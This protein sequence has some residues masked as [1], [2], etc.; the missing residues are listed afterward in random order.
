MK[1]TAP[2]QREASKAA[3]AGIASKA[4]LNPLQL[5]TEGE[6]VPLQMKQNPLVDKTQNQNPLQLSG[7]ENAQLNSNNPLRIRENKTGLPD[8]LKEG[9]ENL[10]GIA[11]DDVKVHYNS[12]KPASLNALAYAQGTNIHLGPGQEQHL[13]HEA[14]HVVQQ[15]Q[16]RVQPTMQM[17]GGTRVNDNKELEL[18]ANVMGEKA[19]K[20]PS[21]NS[22]PIQ[23]VESNN[24]AS[25]I[26][27]GGTIQLIR[28]LFKTR[29]DR[30]KGAILHRPSKISKRLANGTVVI[31]GYEGDD[32]FTKDNKTYRYVYNQ[33]SGARIGYINTNHLDLKDPNKDIVKAPSEHTSITPKTGL[34]KNAKRI[35]NNT[36]NSLGLIEFDEAIVTTFEKVEGASNIIE[37]ENKRNIL[38]K[39][40]INGFL[41]HGTSLTAGVLIA[42]N[43][44]DPNFA[45]SGGA[46]GLLTEPLNAP[47]Y[48]YMAA[49]SKQAKDAVQN[50][51][52]QHLEEY[53][54]GEKE[55]QFCVLKVHIPMNTVLVQDPDLKNAIRTT[56]NCN[57]EIIE[58]YQ[59]LTNC[60][61][62]DKNSSLKKEKEIIEAD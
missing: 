24:F 15:K 41:Y 21:H 49:T 60:K 7:N 58:E 44:L 19:I 32:E 3:I 46:K 33:I 17:K 56:R 29:I 20:V 38:Y 53:K 30:A 37:R 50:F 9:V 59:G 31:A 35:D 55:S 16:G 27:S 62:E 48:I 25:F 57:A 18:E 54:S 22:S 6:E 10:S 28:R 36:V 40:P 4:T 39:M 42:K 13:P 14:W 61:L 5:K 34:D 51:Y 52:Q 8:N 43:G 11:M 1:A 2:L 47:G 45:G 23:L 12:A 26:S